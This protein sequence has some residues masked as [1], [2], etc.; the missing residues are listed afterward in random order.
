MAAQP[1]PGR[2]AATRRRRTPKALSR[3]RTLPASQAAP[4]LGV[5]LQRPAKYLYGF[6][7][8]A[9]VDGGDSQILQRRR[10]GQRTRAA[11]IERDRF[12]KVLAVVV[13]QT[14]CVGGGRRYRIG[15]GD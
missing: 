1:L 9:F 8:V 6:V 11:L 10:V 5:Q 14:S 2:C 4:D 7:C 13:Q 12:G 3:P 15:P